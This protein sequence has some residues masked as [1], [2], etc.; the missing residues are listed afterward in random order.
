MMPN[1]D[2]FRV[3][4]PWPDWRI[5]PNGRLHHQQK[6]K[7]VK[8]HREAARLISMQSIGFQ[9][10]VDADTIFSIWIFRQPDNRKRDTGNMRAAMKACQDG[11]FDVLK[12]DDSAIKPEAL[13]QDGI[14]DGGEVELRLYEDWRM[15][16][17]DVRE[18]TV[19]RY[20][21]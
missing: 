1:L 21:D 19:E 15:W 17:D 18:L 8:S 13:F 4:L 14:V 9:N 7:L 20:A 10:W 6:G 12:I 11:V 2:F 3:V 16:L 5:S